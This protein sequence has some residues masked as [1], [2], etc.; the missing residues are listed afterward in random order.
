MRDL[1]GLEP[2]RQPAGGEERALVVVAV[3]HPVAVD[4]R[5]V[6]EEGH[7]PEGAAVEDVV[8]RGGVVNPARQRPLVALTGMEDALAH[9]YRLAGEQRQR[10]ERERG[11][12]AGRERA[13]SRRHAARQPG[14]DLEQGEQVE[15]VSA[16]NV[17]AAEEQHVAEPQ[18]QV[19]RQHR[20][21]RDAR[22]AEAGAQGAGARGAR[23]E[24]QHDPRAEEGEREA[25]LIGGIHR[26][27][28]DH[29][30]AGREVRMRER[31]LDAGGDRKQAAE[32]IVTPRQIGR[33]DHRGPRRAPPERAPAARRA[34]RQQRHD[35]EGRRQERQVVH[36]RQHQQ[37]EQQA[38][39][40][41]GE[42]AAPQQAAARHPGEVGAPDQH[43]Q[44]R[45]HAELLLRHDEHRVERD[46][47]GDREP[48]PLA[49]EPGGVEGVLEQTDEAPQP[50]EQRRQAEE[51]PD[52]IA[53]D[54]RG[55][56][57]EQ[58]VGAHQ[59]QGLERIESVRGVHA[60][61]RQ[62]VPEADVAR[63][64]EVVPGIVAHQQRGG[65]ARI[66]DQQD[67]GDQREHRR[68]RDQQQAR[69]R[70]RGGHGRAGWAARAALA[71][72]GAV[73]SAAPAPF[74]AARP[75]KW[76]SRSRISRIGAKA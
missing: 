68:A 57:S 6:G 60:V 40:D 73:A 58:P 11:R 47:G 14:R 18:R 39:A 5:P 52:P 55:R 61:E 64:R 63:D 7:Q 27:A 65:N 28:A 22:L 54:H 31:G 48:P 44:R 10:E 71:A 53:V 50:A 36:P 62:A 51:E 76:P 45:V 21:G 30:Q 72:A 19:E 2:A 70:A 25:R 46:R 1:A 20:Q 69:E 56:R 32:P 59:Q 3:R 67:P 16:L 43:H 35:R 23:A 26:A 75:G 34:G 33:D 29:R 9:R 41:R 15:D 13:R 37:P 49:G 74:S 17:G 24:P 12:R 38:V 42:R 8:G 66:G 4:P